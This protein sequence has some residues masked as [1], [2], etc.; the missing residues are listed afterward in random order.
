MA[1]PKALKRNVLSGA[2]LRPLG[3][4]Y[5]S[6]ELTDVGVHFLGGAGKEVLFPDWAGLAKLVNTFGFSTVAIPLTDGTEAK[7]AGV[8]PEEAKGFI[9]VANEAFREHI[10]RQFDTI[11]EELEALSE[12]IRRLEQPRRYPAACLLAPFLARAAKAI[13]SLPAIIPDGFISKENQRLFDTVLAFKD[14]S[15]EVR[16]SA[17]QRFIESELDKM[18]PFFDTI[19]LNPLTPEQRLGY[20]YR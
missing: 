13:E 19:E 2:L 5:R 8:K 20:C 17:I 18:K 11:K 4:S 14:S 7:L 6:A 9:S 10:V 1:S 3:L 16:K 15:D 12:A